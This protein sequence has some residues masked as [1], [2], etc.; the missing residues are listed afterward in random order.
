MKLVEK[1][2][3]TDTLAEYAT[4]IQSGPV[5]VTDQGCPVAALVPIENADVETVSLST[6]PQ[7]LDLIQRSRAQ[8]RKEGGISSQEMRRRFQDTRTENAEQNDSPGL[9]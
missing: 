7:F 4:N 1:I 8:A 5:I 3:A 2:D 6:N 9:E